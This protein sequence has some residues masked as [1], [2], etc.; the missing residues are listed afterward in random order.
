MNT[1]KH[2]EPAPKLPIAELLVVVGLPLISI[3]AGIGL[4]VVSY[5][6]GFADLVTH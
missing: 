6:H 1:M 5:L 4:A 3:M 2:I